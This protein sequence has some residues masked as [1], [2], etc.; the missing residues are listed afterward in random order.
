VAHQERHTGNVGS[1]DLSRSRVVIL[2]GGFGGLWAARALRNAP[3]DIQLFD[4]QNHHLFQP[5]L[6]QVATASL[7]PGDVSAPLRNILAKQKNVTVLL[8]EAAGVDT[9][10]RVV[11]FKDYEDV[12]YDYLIVATGARFTYFGN[13]QWAP[14]APGLKTVRDALTIRQRFLRAFEEAE[15]IDDL[16]QRRRKLTFVVVGGGPTGVEMAGAMAEIARRAMPRDFRRIDTRSAR[17]MLVEGLDRLLPAYPE[18]L[19]ARTKRDLED[20][21]VDV[22]LESFV[23]GVDETG[24]TVG[25]ERI[26][27]EHVVWAAGVGGEA[28]GRAL[29]EDAGVEIGKDGR[30]PVN[31]D[32]TVGSRRNVFVVGD[33]AKHEDPKTGDETPGIAPGAMQMGRHA[34]KIIR[35]ETKARARGR[36]APERKPFRF[37]DKGQLSTIGRARAVGIIRGVKISG[38]LAWLLWLGVH[39]FFLIGFGNRLRVMLSWAYA[40]FTFQHGSR[41]IIEAAETD[42]RALTRR[43]KPRPAQEQSQPVSAGAATD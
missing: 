40:Y 41:L 20:L 13:D 22:R 38:L 23:T 19:N 35:A 7:A 18:P 36:D 31:D 2:G 17:I 21:G 43:E 34:A 6:Y 28:L 26:E 33:L 15:R 4:R 42:P 32:L 24:V 10:R 9:E 39:I 1:G 27:T 16:E 37:L 11:S 8:G 3:V 29:G 12:G 14:L 5:L 30:V 25:D